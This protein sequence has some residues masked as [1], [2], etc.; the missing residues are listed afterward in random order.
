MKRSD[1]IVFLFL[2]FAALSLIPRDVC[3][4][5]KIFEQA[6]DRYRQ[7]QYQEAILLYEQILND[8]QA[9]G[10]LYYNLGNSYFKTGR[11]GMA[12]LN[13]E[14]ARKYIPKDSDLRA[15]YAFALSQVKKT[16]ST[17]NPP[18]IKR[19]LDS[20][21]RQFS[22]D[23]IARIIF[24]LYACGLISAVVFMCSRWSSVITRVV[25]GLIAVLLVLHLITFFYKKDIEAG[26]AVMIGQ[27]DALFEPQ[28]KAT[29]HFTLFDGTRVR[30][31]EQREDWIKVQRLDGKMGWSRSLA[32]TKI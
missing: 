2:A 20:Y 25:L 31:I 17:Q 7:G 18:F 15:N 10:A 21:H 6:N 5:T 24:V 9:S 4:F 32:V 22:L 12:I 8:G 28:M 29:K 11:V 27:E 1:I 19:M 13:Y 30:I 16:S 14:R 23:L 26:A 3:A